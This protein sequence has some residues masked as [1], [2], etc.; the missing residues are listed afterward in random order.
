MSL[1][2]YV[3]FDGQCEE[4]LNFYASCLNGEITYLGRYGESPMDVPEDQKN[5]IMHATVTFEGGSI[6]GSDRS[7]HANYT[8]E[9]KMA[10]NI[11]LSLTVSTDKIQTVFEA[12]ADGGKITLPLEKQFWGD[13]FGMLTD[14]FGTNWMLSGRENKEGE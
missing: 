2:P 5:K 1:S 8:P 7:D 14:K 4:A 9:G 6:M 10:S 3:M 13:T 11:H 12:L